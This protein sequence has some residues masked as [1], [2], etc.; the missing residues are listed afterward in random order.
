V[1]Y[2]QM[3]LWQGDQTS[4]EASE[5]AVSETAQLDPS[6]CCPGT[7]RARPFATTPLCASWRPQN[8]GTASPWEFGICFSAGRTDFSG[9]GGEGG[10]DGGGQPGSSLQEMGS[11]RRAA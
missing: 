2:W 1:V 8:L 4:Q 6:G 9:K 3:I 10:P 5:A 11:G 7:C